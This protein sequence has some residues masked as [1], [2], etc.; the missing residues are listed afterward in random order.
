MSEWKVGVKYG[1]LEDTSKKAVTGMARKIQYTTGY[2]QDMT[3]D[4]QTYTARNAIDLM[5]VVHFN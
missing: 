1:M 4:E 2:T 5:Q 3:C